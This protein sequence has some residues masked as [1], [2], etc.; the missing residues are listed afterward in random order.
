MPL[1]QSALAEGVIQLHVLPVA[2]TEM[3]LAPDWQVLNKEEQAQA[4]RF[5]FD[6][7]RQLYL[8]AHGL[9]RRCLS[10]Y[11]DLPPAAWH[12]QRGPGGKPGL[13]PVHHP[14]L[15]RLHFNLSHCRGMVALAL[16]W[17]RPLGVDVE[18]LE[19]LSEVDGL[20]SVVLAPTE[21]H[22]YL[23]AEPAMR[24][25]FLLERWTLKESVL[26]A[27]GSGLGEYAPDSVAFVDA[28]PHGWRLA[29]PL[30]DGTDWLFFSRWLNARHHVALAVAAPLPGAPQ[31]E[32]LIH[33]ET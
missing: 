11:G 30:G 32:L 31:S 15:G 33:V 12:F 19:S 26:K 16:C 3:D 8:R 17:G 25:R 28:A 21:R 7:D 13:C 1:H 9:L 23:A 10:L 20:S 27:M 14:E 5:H 18:N 22:C 24:R 4:L 29:G 2:E 6:R